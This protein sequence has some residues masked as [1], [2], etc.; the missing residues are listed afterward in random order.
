[1]S[2]PIRYIYASN[3]HFS[4]DS[5]HLVYEAQTDNQFFLV[6]DGD[7]GRPYDAILPISKVGGEIVFD[8]L[9]RFHYLAQ[10]DNGIYLMEETL[11]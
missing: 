8:S 6:V 11:R 2:R 9:T 1:M 7:E 5:Q 3:L 4:P 10:K